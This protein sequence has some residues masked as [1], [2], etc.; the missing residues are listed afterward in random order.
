M[1][2][3][4]LKISLLTA[5]LF[6]VSKGVV[7]AANTPAMALTA[8]TQKFDISAD[9]AN[10]WKA[11]TS[12]QTVSYS[13]KPATSFEDAFRIQLGGSQAPS[14]HIYFSNYN[15]SEIYKFLKSIEPQI[16]KPTSEPKY[17]EE[18]GVVVEFDPGQSGVAMDINKSLDE[19]ISGLEKNKTTIELAYSTTEPLQKLADLNNRG[20][21][22]LVAEGNSDFSGSPNNRIFNI[23]VGVKKEAGILLAPGEE[24]SFNKFLGPV[25]GE[26]GFLPELVIKANGTIPEFGGGLCQVSSTVFRAAVNAGLPITAR[27][28]HSYAVKYYSPQGTDATIYPGSQDLKFVNNTS[29]Y[30]LVWPTFP[31]KNKLRF[32]LYGT[33]DT[34]QVALD[35][36]Y[37][38]DKKADGSLKAVW[39]RTT[40]MPDGTVLKDSWNST[41]LPPALFHK[42]ETTTPTAPAQP[43]PSPAPTPTT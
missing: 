27:R 15:V 41:Y 40:T 35:G 18:S 21:K 43:D 7:F 1:H 16:N 38:Y 30:L 42:V 6:F 14:S 5:A 9:Q 11:Q 39:R 3:N 25:D 20:I 2:R 36:P 8:G 19:I 12:E 17:K 37:S 34:R 10:N 33:K 26:H 24:F 32:S 28:N 31:E 29:S 22:E 4:I 13:F 23:K